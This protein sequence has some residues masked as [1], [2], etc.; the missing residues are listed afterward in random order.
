MTSVD[1]NTSTKHSSFH[2][3]KRTTRDSLECGTCLF[4]SNLFPVNPGQLDNH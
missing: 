1:G 2:G 3:T 4:R